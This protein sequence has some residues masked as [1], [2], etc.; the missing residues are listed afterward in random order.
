[1]ASAER[2]RRLIVTADDFGASTSINQAVFE[3]HHKGILTCASLMVN[4]HAFD[5]AVEIARLCPNL[6]VGLHLTLCCG[7]ATLEVEDVPDLVNDDGTFRRAAVAAGFAFY[8]FRRLREQL[9][10]E[11]AAQFDKFA[12]TG[13]RMDHVNGHLHFQM[14]PQ[15]LS[16]LI[17]EMKKRG[18]RAVR[19][20]NEPIAVDAKLGKGR[21]LYRWSH[22]MIFNRLSACARPLLRREGLT[23][24]AHVFGLLQDSRI[25]EEYLLKLVPEIPPGNSELYAHPSL[26]EFSHEYLALVSPKVKAAIHERGIELV[27]YQDL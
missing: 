12:A 16:L 18:V 8:F 1:M 23:H 15:V 14:H 20:T 27:R 24:P 17:P 3:A 6:G 22:W 19:L 5:E 4:G 2:R 11:I 10:K 26:E 21:L 13:L 25:T 9:S 7:R